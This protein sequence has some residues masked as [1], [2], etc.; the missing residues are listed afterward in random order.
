MTQTAFQSATIA[1]QGLHC[2]NCAQKVQKALTAT[3]GVVEAQVDLSQNSAQI[4]FDPQS[5]T[6]AKLM[7]AITQTGY[8]ATGFT[9]N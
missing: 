1:I 3:P 5:V 2:Q 6:I 8:P 7:Q 4:R 9:K